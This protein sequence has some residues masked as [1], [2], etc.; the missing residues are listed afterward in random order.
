MKLLLIFTF[1]NIATFDIK[2][3]DQTI[4]VQKSK[5]NFPLLSTN[6]F[7][8]D[9]Q[10]FILNSYFLDKKNAQKN[11]KVPLHIKKPNKELTRI[12]YS[13]YVA[14]TEHV[15]HHKT[16]NSPWGETLIVADHGKDVPHLNQ[17]G[18]ILAFTYSNTRN[19]FLNI[20]SHLNLEKDFYFNI[21]AP[22]LKKSNFHHLILPTY[23]TH[24]SKVR[25]LLAEQ[26]GYSDQSHMLPKDWTSK[27]L[28]F[29]TG[30]E[31]DLEADGSD[32]VI[33]GGC[34]LEKPKKENRYDR[35]LKFQNGA[36]NFLNE[37]TL[38]PR[39]GGDGWG[40]AYIQK[41]NLQDDKKEEIVFL[42][43]NKEITESKIQIVKY[44]KNLKRFSEI[45]I[46][47]DLNN[48]LPKKPFYYHKSIAFDF[49]HD[50]LDDIAVQVIHINSPEIKFPNV[51]FFKNQKDKFKYVGYDFI[52]LP[53]IPVLG[54]DTLMENGKKQVVFAFDSGEILIRSN[55]SK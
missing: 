19:S 14:L 30:I 12:N 18:N 22:K 3:K 47:Y 38:P 44:N 8:L 52:Q 26:K 55:N 29:M 32:E 40:T 39:I 1:F 45:P 25:F 4:L 11:L 6:F 10:L 23:N 48:P 43:H 51:V 21:I 7:K 16:I 46:V 49:D 28:C 31:F 5:T 15:R 53:K 2:A 9:D 27:K 24:F 50:G 37:K 34:D 33:L 36:W 20:S 17:G 13:Y 42:T 41:A 35:V 54:I